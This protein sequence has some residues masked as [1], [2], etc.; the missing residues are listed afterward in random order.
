MA[1]KSG[2]WTPG[3]GVWGS[4][5]AV[6]GKSVSVRGL[7]AP[8]RSEAPVERKWKSTGG[9]PTSHPAGAGSLAA[10]RRRRARPALAGRPEGQHSRPAFLGQK[11]VHTQKEP[12][13]VCSVG[14]GQFLTYVLHPSPISFSL[15]AFFFLSFFPL[16]LSLRSP[17]TCSPTNSITPGTDLGTLTLL[18]ESPESTHMGLVIWAARPPSEFVLPG[19]VWSL[20]LSFL[21]GFSARAKPPAY[22]S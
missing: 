7:R 5:K 20:E 17:T 3:G 8:S 1:P 14:L 4:R 13:R 6:G 9:R 10:A 18:S 12:R 19:R 21:V 22:R 11:K 15:L 2:N 16:H